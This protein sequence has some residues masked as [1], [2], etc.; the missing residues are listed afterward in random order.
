MVTVIVLDVLIF[1]IGHLPKYWLRMVFLLA[2]LSTKSVRETTPCL[3][4]HVSILPS[5]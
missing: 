3:G 2:E 5:L 4:A 1:I